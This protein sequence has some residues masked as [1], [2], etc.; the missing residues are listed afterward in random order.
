MQNFKVAPKW[1]SPFYIETQ[2]FE[3]FIQTVV[4]FFY[5]ETQNFENYNQT[6]IRFSHKEIQ[7][8]TYLLSI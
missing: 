4:R 3:N 8:L 2:H 1:P 7:N 6:A 5:K